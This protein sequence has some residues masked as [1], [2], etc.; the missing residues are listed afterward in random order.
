M[1]ESTTWLAVHYLHLI[2][3][4]FFV[5]GQLVV[6]AAVVPVERRYTDRTR[7]R[8]IGRR[9]GAGSVLALVVLA[10]T[11]IAMADHYGYWSSGTLQVKLILVGIVVVLTT[12]HLFWPRAHVLSAVVFLVSLAI[13]WFGLELVH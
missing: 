6:A 8:A 11:G 10:A 12:G 2:A 3:M 13:V 5:G 4:A 1:E 7:M 9:F